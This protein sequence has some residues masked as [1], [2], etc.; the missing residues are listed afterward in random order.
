[1]C[2]NTQ[3]RAEVTHILGM[4]GVFTKELPSKQ[5]KKDEWEFSR[6]SK[7]HS[8]KCEEGRKIWSNIFQQTKSTEVRCAPQTQPWEYHLCVLCAL[9]IISFKFVNECTWLKTWLQLHHPPNHYLTTHCFNS[10]QSYF[11]FQSII[12]TCNLVLKVTIW[13]KSIYVFPKKK[14]RSRLGRVGELFNI[15]QP[16]NSG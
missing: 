3:R 15:M 4:N 7:E 14:S 2:T 6:Q 9:T 10:F 12:L 5:V 16:R 8:R 13:V 1:M 11:S